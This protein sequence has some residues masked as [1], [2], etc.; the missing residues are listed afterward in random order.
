MT[1]SYRCECKNDTWEILTG[2]IICAHCGREYE[3]EPIK[4]SSCYTLPSAKEFN[5]NRGAMNQ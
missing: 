5:T 4:G 1:E 3:L 2:R